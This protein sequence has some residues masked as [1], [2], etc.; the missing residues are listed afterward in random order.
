M[1]VPVS[2]VGRTNIMVDFKWF[3]STFNTN[4]EDYVNVQYST[5]GIAWN[6]AGKVTGEGTI[7]GWTTQTVPLPAAANGQATLYV[8][9]DFHSKHWFNC[10]LDLVHIVACGPLPPAT[11]TIGSG[12]VGCGYPYSTLW[13]GG[14]TQL[15]YNASDMTAAGATPGMINSIGF[16]V[17]S[18]SLQ[19]MQNFNIRM[20]NTSLAAFNGWVSGLQS[21][22]SGSYAVAGTGWQMITL[23]T[24]FYWDGSNV[25]LEICYG[26]NGSYTNNTVLSGTTVSAGLVQP[27]WQDNTIGC[28]YSGLPITGNTGRPNLRFVENPY[29]GSLTGKVINCFNNFLLP[30][31]IVTCGSHTT[32]TNSTG[33]YIFYNLPPGNYNVNYSISDFTSKAIPVTLTN[34]AP[35]QSN[36]CLDPIPAHFTGIVTSA[37]T[38][39][40]IIGA[41]ISMV[42]QVTYSTGPSGSF[43]MDVYPVGNYNAHV[44]KPGFEDSGYGVLVFTP[45]NTIVQNYTMFET[46][47]PPD[48][49]QAVLNAGQTAVNITWGVPKGNYELLYDD[50]VQDAFFQWPVGGNYNAVRFTPA[51]YPCV[52]KGGSFNMGI[53]SNYVSGS[54]P[55][56]PFQF[57]VFDDSG[58]GGTPGNQIGGPFNAMPS[59]YGWSNFTFFTPVT[60]SSGSFYLV[61]VQGG[62]APNAAGI[63][64]DNTSNQLRSYSKTMPSGAWTQATG[65]FLIR[66]LVNGP[67]GPVPLMSLN[68]GTGLPGEATDTPENSGTLNGGYQVWR[69]LQGQEWIPAVW[70]PVGTP[71][72]LTQVDNAW[73]AL[74]CNPYLWAVKAQYT[75]GH[76]SQAAISNSIGKCWSASV[77]VNVTL[78]CQGES[79]SGTFLKLQNNTY[80]DTIYQVSMGPSGTYTF[81]SVSKGTYTLTVNKYGY[82]PSVQSSVTVGSNIINNVQLQQN[83]ISPT[84]LAI[85]SHTLLATWNLPDFS[86]Y[87][88]NEDW[89]GGAFFFNGWTV[90]GGSNWSITPFAGNGAPAVTFQSLPTVTGYDQYLTSANMIGVHSPFLKLKYDIFLSNISAPGTNFM[91]VEIWDGMTWVVLKSYSSMANIP[92]TTDSVD[93]SGYTHATFNI[94]FHAS[95]ANSS[96]ISNWKIDNIK[97]IANDPTLGSCLGGY[98]FYLNGTLQSFTMANSFAI[99]SDYALYGQTLNACVIASYSSGASSQVCTPFVVKYLCFPTNLSATDDGTT[100]NLTWTKPSCSLPSQD[101]FVYDDGTMENGWMFWPGTTMWLGNKMNAGSGQSGQLTSIRMRWWDVGIG[102][103]QSFQVDIFDMSG[104]L[105]GSSPA[106]VV[107]VP[108]PSSYMQV[109]LPTPIAYSGPFYC[110]VKWSNLTGNSH[111]MGYD[112]NGPYSTPGLAYVYD[113]VSFTPWSA[114]VPGTPGVFCI[115][116]CGTVSMD[117]PVVEIGPETVAAEGTSK[118]ASGIVSSV[119]AGSIP[120]GPVSQVAG[121]TASG[122]RLDSPLSDPMLLGYMVYMAPDS[123]GP[124]SQVQY[125]EGADILTAAVAGLSPGVHWFR[126]T[127]YYD[128]SPIGFPGTFDES[129]STEPKAVYIGVVPYN[130]YV[131]DLVVNNGQT[132]CYDAM[133][134]ITIAGPGKNFTVSDGGSASMVAGQKISYLAGTRVLP[135]GYM[136]GSITTTNQFCSPGKSPEGNNLTGEVLL[137]EGT[138]GLALFKTWPNPTDG[139]VT[140]EISKNLQSCNASLE[141]YGLM[142]ERILTRPMNGEKKTVISLQ[143]HARGIYFIRLSTGKESATAKIILR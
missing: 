81:P 110:M 4:L 111:Y 1:T 12:T 90:S 25:I 63:T 128:L 34:G 50:G 74:P 83:M 3:T 38:G 6:T 112:Q 122:S 131:S 84:N 31:V 10:Y 89:S 92:W 82:A 130:L 134:I 121:A 45:G 94:R 71:T 133:N 140:V 69:L 36:T 62:D 97:I 7:Y 85:D 60:V 137:S 96:S 113:G 35:T 72:A 21:C 19:T 2:T 47:N 129:T 18:A 135:G 17:T 109:D 106:F 116:A 120:P 49:P 33:D 54:Y 40:P 73:P 103:A 9:F 15:L 93:I 105:L 80:L 28:S 141:I 139:D 98:N 78:S 126:I 70:V 55:L 119:P 138:A 26:N 107:P 65:N 46:V 64:I 77:T 102:T 27:Y 11:V 101:C 100:A 61:Q 39:N 95:G 37:T 114:Y 23:Q 52:V 53:Q 127:A 68:P 32:T 14:R 88:L 136:H 42:G 67:G 117:G 132:F 66:A 143:G 8:A 108:A 87:L 125:I 59:N 58:P 24:P 76:W 22:Y 124:Y 44:A 41:Q 91:K 5:N 20:M 16:N 99:P 118:A 30:G 115:V 75:G 86:S 123:I 142:G 104:L 51:A 48:N 43:S 13:M 56:V 29:S 57:L 79:T